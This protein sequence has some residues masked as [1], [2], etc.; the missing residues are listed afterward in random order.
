VAM[1]QAVVEHVVWKRIKEGPCWHVR[2]SRFPSIC[3]LEAATGRFVIGL[4]L[5][6]TTTNATSPLQRIHELLTSGS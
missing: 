5:G 4:G 1:D 6:T 2:S 3:L